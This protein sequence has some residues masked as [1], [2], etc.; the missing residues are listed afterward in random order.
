MALKLTL[1]MDR[2]G[3][4]TG[5]LLVVTILVST[6]AQ[7]RSLAMVIERIYLLRIGNVAQHFLLCVRNWFEMKIL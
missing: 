6:I 3:S 5:H 2:F 4:L 1:T 7:L